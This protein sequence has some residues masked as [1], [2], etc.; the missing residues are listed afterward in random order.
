MRI[1]VSFDASGIID[2]LAGVSERLENLSPALEK[3]GQT[4]YAVSMESFA[5]E[6]SPWGVPWAQLA[7]RTI[8]DR[9]G[10]AHPI[11]Y[12]TGM[13]KNSISSVVTSA[14][15]VEV[16]ANVDYAKYHMRGIESRN[17][18]ARP[19]LGFSLSTPT[20]LENILANHLR[21]E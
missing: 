21:G 5:N 4:L 1:N 19:F 20:V 18:P 2:H 17:L 16:G 15:S 14:N 13:L 7:E 11:L 12:R 8:K 10:E 6:T 9:G 3:I